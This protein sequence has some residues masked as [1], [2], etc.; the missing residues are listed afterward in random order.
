MLT[1]TALTVYQKSVTSNQEVW[2]RSVVPAVH[3]ENRKAANVLASGLLKADSVSVWVPLDGLT[4]EFAVGDV[5]V[6]GT[7][8]N[9]VDHVTYT[10]TDLMAEYPN[11]VR[12][13][14]VDRYDYG[15]TRMQHVRLGAA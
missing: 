9:E 5:L 6:K 15:S 10:L 11:S 14:S 8:T 3:W 7:V 4:V 12:V 2:T 1:N 13:T